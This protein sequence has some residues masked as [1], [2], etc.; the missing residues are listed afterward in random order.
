MKKKEM[1]PLTKEENKIHREQK[2]CYVSRKGF[3]TDDDDNKKYYKG[4]DHC[5]YTGKYRGAALDICNLRYKTPK[6]ISVVIHNGS[7]YDYNFIIKELAEEFEGQFECLGEN[8]EKYITFSVPIKKGLGNGKSIAYKIKFID[9]FMSSSL[10]SLVDILPEGL[11]SD[12]CTDFKSCLDYMIIKDDQLIFRCFEWKKNYKKDLNNELIKR[13][14]NIYELC[15]E[16]INKFNLLLRKGVCPCEYMDNWERFDE[17]SLPDKEAFYSSLNN[18][19]GV[20]YRHAKRVFKNLNNKN[21]SDYH[22]LYVQSDTSLLA[23][24]FE[25]FRNKCIEIYELD[26]PHFLFAP[27]LSWQACLKKQR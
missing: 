24:V 16:D 12:K 15:N 6:E 1:I 11:H 26:P 9:S 22:V 20:D 21:L 18:T 2:F 13:S 17:T 25:N 23:D 10:S 5:H 27:G 7:T 14:A 19:A 3:R 4:R 8:T